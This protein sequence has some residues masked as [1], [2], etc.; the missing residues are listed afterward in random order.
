M[1]DIDQELADIEAKFGGG[2]SQI[3]PEK[4]RAQQLAPVPAARPTLGQAVKSEVGSEEERLRKELEALGVEAAPGEVRLPPGMKQAATERATFGP[5]GREALT[6]GAIGAGIPLALGATRGPA[7]IA[8]AIPTAIGGGIEAAVPTL[9]GE[10]AKEMVPAE[11]RMYSDPALTA[12]EM[13]SPSGFARLSR[14]IEKPVLHGAQG[15][16]ARYARLF[17]QQGG[18]LYPGQLTLPRGALFDERNAR[19]VNQMVT[20]SAGN[21]SNVIDESWFN[22]TRRN[23]SR[24]YEN[25]IYSPSNMFVYTPGQEHR[26]QTAFSVPMGAVGEAPA[27]IQRFQNRLQTAFPGLFEPRLIP[28]PGGAGFMLNPNYTGMFSGAEWQRAHDI[29]NEAR[30]AGNYDVRQWARSL[31]QT[32]RD[33]T[34]ALD[35]T[36][37]ALYQQTNSQWRSLRVL[38]DLSEADKIK[39][40]FVDVEALG[41][42]LNKEDPTFKGRGP[43]TG[44]ELAGKVG[45]N[46]NVR[47]TPLT[48][49]EM[50]A[51]RAGGEKVGGAVG[52]LLGAGTG[53]LLGGGIGTTA[54]VPGVAVGRMI[55]GAVAPTFT[56]MSR[57]VFGPA[58]RIMQRGDVTRRFVEP[59]VT[60][61]TTAIGATRA[62]PY[63]MP[64]EEPPQ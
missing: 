12:L 3:S 34:R 62:A 60:P 4:L 31:D 44:L 56:E 64:G 1:A 10:T 28:A 16:I 59:G 14:A 50:Q 23:L 18:R 33:T 17:E 6:A 29:L 48:E 5:A 36:V 43:R 19:V 39:R 58:G 35:P 61:A 45:E 63:V 2:G 20:R 13:L 9:I 15:D 37:N 27:A 54:G 25:Q 47:T 42:V 53:Y 30:Q 38:E 11:Y 40:G 46:L 57:Q 21:P 32:I 22:T 7:G 55:G 49:A 26:L 24:I 51:Q 41:N 8:A 52:G